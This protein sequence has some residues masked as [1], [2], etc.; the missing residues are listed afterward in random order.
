MSSIEIGLWSFPVLILLIF[1]RVPI[2]AAMLA[3]GTI[4]SIWCSGAGRR[5]WPR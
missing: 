3:V 5:S 2:G 4:G 1:M